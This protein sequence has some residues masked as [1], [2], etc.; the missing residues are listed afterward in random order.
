MASSSGFSRRGARPSAVTD[1]DHPS[2]GKKLYPTRQRCLQIAG[3]RQ[4]ASRQ[5]PPSPARIAVSPTPTAVYPSSETEHEAATLFLA[6]R[7]YAQ[8]RDER[9]PHADNALSRLAVVL[10]EPMRT[11]VSLIAQSLARK[12]ENNRFVRVL[13]VLGWAKRRTVSILYQSARSQNVHEQIL[14][15]YYLKAEASATPPTSWATPSGSTTSLSP[16]AWD[17]P[18]WV[19]HELLCISLVPRAWGEPNGKNVAGAPRTSP[20]YETESEARTRTN[21]RRECGRSIELEVY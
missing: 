19:S 16:R 1:C 8:G 20:T 13:E 7:L 11:Q 15:P 5:S 6:I 21:C 9:N 12:P 14:W 3:L 4:A 18:G 2:I 10:P 17:E